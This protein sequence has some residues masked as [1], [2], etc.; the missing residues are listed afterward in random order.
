[1]DFSAVEYAGKKS[2]ILKSLA[3]PCTV[4]VKGSLCCHLDYY[5][6]TTTTPVNSKCALK[7][8]FGA[9]YLMLGA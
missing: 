1:M 3:K 4:C 7:L 9:W 8:M 5:Y 2:R 6:S